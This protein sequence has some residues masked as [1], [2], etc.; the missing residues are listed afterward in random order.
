MSIIER[1]SFSS[2]VEFSDYCRVWRVVHYYIYERSPDQAVLDALSNLGPE[3][4]VVLLN[5]ADDGGFLSGTRMTSEIL[6]D[7]IRFIGK[8]LAEFRGVGSRARGVPIGFAKDA[9]EILHL[10]A[11]SR[12]FAFPPAVR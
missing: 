2:D 6:R 5:V 9:T 8:P 4:V 1:R 12:R 11:E 7:P 10:I 3:E